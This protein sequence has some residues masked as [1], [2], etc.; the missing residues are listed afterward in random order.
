MSIGTFS[1]SLIVAPEHP[2]ASVPEPKIE[3]LN[4]YRELV[5]R[6]RIGMAQAKAIS[7]NHWHIDS[8]Y[9]ITELVIRGIGWALVP[10]HVAKVNWYQNAL[11][12]LS[13]AHITDP[14]SVEMGIV[15]RRDQATGPVTEWI[16]HT[17]SKGVVKS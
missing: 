1:Q 13:T 14:L 17:L 6:D 8:Y 12:E 16:Y 2:L 15:K 9:Y 3:Q 4:Q 5:I 11:V 7:P 10:E